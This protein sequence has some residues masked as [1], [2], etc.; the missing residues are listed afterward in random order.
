MNIVSKLTL[1][2]T[3]SWGFFVQ[4]TP[5]SAEFRFTCE[6]F[7]GAYNFCSVD[8]R[9][10]VRLLRQLSRGDCRYGVSWGY[11][12]SGVWVDRGCSAEFAVRDTGGDFSS[13]NS[14]NNTAAIIGG[15]LAIGAIAAALANNNN[16]D[17]NRITCS[18]AG[19]NYT[20]CGAD[21]R[22]GDRVVLRRQL[23][24]AGCWEGNTWGYDR[25]G[26][27]VTQGCRGVFEITRW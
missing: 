8:T 23:S 2:G 19:G 25:D 16:S 21:I 17:G 15:A 22:R 20:R 6:S 11:D 27:W 4:A 10:G 9:G 3:I 14:G 18:S 24:N 26:I 13:N 5:A 7:R 1:I 12:R